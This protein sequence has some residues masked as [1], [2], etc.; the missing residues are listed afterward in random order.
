[1]I[2]E[3]SVVSEAGMEQCQPCGETSTDD[4]EIFLEITKR[5]GS[6]LVPRLVWH[7]IVV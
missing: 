6:H 3:K 2:S 4:G 1:V 7:D 5:R